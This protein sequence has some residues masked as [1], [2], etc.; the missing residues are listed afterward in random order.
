MDF[1]DRKRK[2]GEIVTCSTAA[3]SIWPP[4]EIDNE[5][6]SHACAVRRGGKEQG[7]IEDEA[8]G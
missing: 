2:R 8:A 6:M 3:A 7:G 5:V 4:S 1:I